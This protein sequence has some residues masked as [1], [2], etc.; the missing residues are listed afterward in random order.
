MTVVQNAARIAVSPARLFAY[1]T[2][3]A[4]WPQWHPSSVRVTGDTD[5]PLLAG[6]SC[7]EEFVVAG[8][9]GACLWTVRER[10]PDARWVIDTTTRG[11]YA[12]IEY[13]LEADG[14]GTRFTRTLQYRM[15]NVLLA[16]LDVLVIRRR[17]TRESSLALQ[18]LQARVEALVPEAATA[19]GG[20]RLGPS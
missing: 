11:G 16:L 8:R 5:H 7:T 3:P 6:E 18:R 15:P 14:D 20:G 10:E 2:T 4:N 13:A 9:S 19:A 17:I 1:V 12:R